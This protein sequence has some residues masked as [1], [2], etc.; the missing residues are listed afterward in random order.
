MSQL[1]PRRRSPRF[2]L[3]RVVLMFA[4]GFVAAIG[5]VTTGGAPGAEARSA[6]KRDCGSD[7]AAANTSLRQALA[8]RA[9]AR[10]GELILMP[11]EDGGFYPIQTKA[12]A[13]LLTLQL[14]EGKITRR[15]L[16]D[17]VRLLSKRRAATIRALTEIVDDLHKERNE[18]AA[19][20]ANAAK[21]KPQEGAFPGGTATTMTLTVGGVTVTTDLKTNKQNPPDPTTK[22]SS[23]A[24]LT[25]SVTLDGTLPP[26]WSVVV[27]HNGSADIVLNSATGGSFTL[28]PISP[29]W[30]AGTRPGAYICSTPAPPLCTPSAQ[31]NISIDWDP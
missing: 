5:L 1:T 29:A 27:F 12:Y 23:P 9:E 24:G 30:D 2:A 25:G 4:I 28:K 18:I 8:L 31:A 19:K 22:G 11:G 7:L 14:L 26:G 13:G 6:A 15:D 21:P 3:R 20:C 10:Q 16:R 17:L